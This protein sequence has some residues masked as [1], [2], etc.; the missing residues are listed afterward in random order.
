MLT[1]ST[2]PVKKFTRLPVIGTF[3]RGSAFAGAI[4]TKAI[5]VQTLNAVGF[6]A[7]LQKLAAL[8]RD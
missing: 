3:Q 2:I 7:S 4:C 5:Q 6:D 1:P 8:K